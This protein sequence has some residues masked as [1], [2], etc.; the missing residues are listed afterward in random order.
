MKIENM[1]N[2]KSLDGFRDNIRG[3]LSDKKFTDSLGG[4]VLSENLT[5]TDPRLLEKKYPD[6]VFM[7][8]GIEINNTGGYESRIESLRVIGQGDFV[9]SSDRAQ[10]KGKVSLRA[11]KSF[12]D[13][14]ELATSADWT[15]TDIKTSA[16][17]NVNLVS[18]LLDIVNKQYLRKLD[19]I[20]LLGLEVTNG[21]TG[22][23][24]LLNSTDFTATAASGLIS[25][26]T[27]TEKYDVFAKLITD[28]KDAVSNTADYTANKV[29]MPTR[30][31]N[32]LKKTILNTAA[33][34]DTVLTA[35]QK[36]FPEIEFIASFRADTVANNGNLATSAVVAYNTS[37]ES[38]VY[39]VPSPLEISNQIQTGGFT[40]NVEAKF[41]V[42]GLDVLEPTTGRILTGL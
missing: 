20:G 18:R 27:A 17:Q 12:L 40:Y 7:N 9:L 3:L 8:S 32:D 39:R 10:N 16:L 28:Q 34:T 6:L 4:L 38:M 26:L 31:H 21:V 22:S 24:G 30:V 2:L 33:S 41:R 15:D 29:V 11:E 19:A 23:K 42:A 13:V 5:A 37:N 14:E 1:Y 25:T 35:L 36:N